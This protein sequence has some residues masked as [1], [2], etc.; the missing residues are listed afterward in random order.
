MPSATAAR[1]VLDASV[2]VRAG[3]DA[4]PEA[5]AWTG[6]LGASLRGY[7]PDLLWAEVASALRLYVASGRMT[8][9]DGAEILAT[10]LRLPIHLQSTSDAAPAALDIALTRGL[11]AYDAFYCV[12]AESLD[13]PLV[14]ADR[15]LAEAAARAELIA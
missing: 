13:A 7:A 10:A 8:K 11:S 9:A 6:R 15:R 3:V 4:S 12:L 5:R 1:A 14:T 2:V